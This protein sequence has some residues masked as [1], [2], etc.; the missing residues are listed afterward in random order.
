MKI[1]ICR[2]WIFVMYLMLSW[3]CF[4]ILT[5]LTYN[6][7]VIQAYLGLFSMRAVRDDNV[8]KV[9]A[10][11]SNCWDWDSLHSFISSFRRFISSLELIKSTSFSFM[12]EN[13]NQANKN[14]INGIENK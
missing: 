6:N 14:L 2:Y 12:S 8:A 1:K 7:Q 9:L 4:N 11:A 3:A 10:M 5:I 13:D